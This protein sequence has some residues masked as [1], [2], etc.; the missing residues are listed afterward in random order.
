M[1]EIKS[2]T[3]KYGDFTAVDN[4]DLT[5]E[6][7]K[8]EVFEAGISFIKRLAKAESVS[9][10]SAAEV[11]DAVQGV[12]SEARV[13]IPYSELVD[14]EKEIEKLN[15]ELASLEKD[16]K[17]LEGRLNNPQFL[18]KAPEAVVQG[19]KDKHE[20]LITRKQLILD[21]LEKLK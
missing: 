21:S 13:L 14:R 9:V 15:R 17:G 10:V 1:I 6:T 7:A 11:N 3:K 8:K 12:T 18:S 2:L 4:L 20:K 5:I 19:E 16:L